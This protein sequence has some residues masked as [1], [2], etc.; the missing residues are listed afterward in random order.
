MDSNVTGFRVLYLISKF[1]RH[2]STTRK[3]KADPARE[4]SADNERVGHGIWTE[5]EDRVVAGDVEGA[6]QVL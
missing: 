4:S 6:K 1:G 3:G 2:E 5:D